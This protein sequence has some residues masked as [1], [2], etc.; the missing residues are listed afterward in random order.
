MVLMKKQKPSEALA[1]GLQKDNQRYEDSIRKIKS[2]NKS[3]PI[4]RVPI[5]RHFAAQRTVCP[6]AVDGY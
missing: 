6:T 4:G 2:M 3:R 5:V 1:V